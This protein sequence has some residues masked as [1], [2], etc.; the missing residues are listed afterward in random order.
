MK[1]DRKIN[2]KLMPKDYAQMWGE[3][4]PYSQVRGANYLTFVLL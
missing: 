2:K 3:D 4:G 1:K